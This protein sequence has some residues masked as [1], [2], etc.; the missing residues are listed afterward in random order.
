MRKL[1]EISQ[2][3]A[4]ALMTLLIFVGC[5]GNPLENVSDFPRGLEAKEA[6]MWAKRVAEGKLPSLTGTAPRKS[7]RRQDEFRWL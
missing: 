2:T 3:L 5:S 6:P 7:T 1:I 4:K